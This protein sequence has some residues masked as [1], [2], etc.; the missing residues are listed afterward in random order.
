MSLVAYIHPGTSSVTYAVSGVCCQVLSGSEEIVSLTADNRVAKIFEEF[1]QVTGKAPPELTVHTTTYHH[2]ITTGLP[3]SQRAR[4]LA[5]DHLKEIK[6][7]F[8]DFIA[9]G[10][11]QT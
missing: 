3:V 8:D 2:V 4:R 9:Q 5:P 6:R 7:I 1:S 10:C 11:V